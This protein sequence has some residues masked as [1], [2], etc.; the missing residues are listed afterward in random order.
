MVSA[1]DSLLSFLVGVTGTKHMM[2]GL[3]DL[4]AWGGQVTIVLDRELPR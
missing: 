1:T 2:G 4:S 3:I